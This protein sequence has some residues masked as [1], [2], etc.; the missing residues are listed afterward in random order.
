MDRG[1]TLR[2]FDRELTLRPDG[3]RRGGYVLLDGERSLATM[4]PKREGKRPLD[5][6][7]DDEALDAGLLLF[8]AF[9]VQAY[10][11]DASFSSASTGA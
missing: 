10:T 2:W 11:D 4:T 7:A 9:I 5:V 1:E 3:L 6:I 8:I